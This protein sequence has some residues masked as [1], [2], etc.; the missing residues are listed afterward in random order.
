MTIKT[1]GS[2]T[3]VNPMYVYG[4]CGN[5]SDPSSI[6]R[7]VPDGLYEHISYENP[8][9]KRSGNCRH[10]KITGKLNKSS[11]NYDMRD[12]AC[13]QGSVGPNSYVSDVSR[14]IRGE[15]YIKTELFELPDLGQLNAEAYETMKPSLVAGF[16]LTNFVLELRDVR[17]MFDIWKRADSYVKNIGAGYL[18]YQFGWKLF[19]HDVNDIWKKLSTWEKSLEDYKSKQGKPC[20]RHFRKVLEPQVGYFTYPLSSG[21]ESYNWYTKQTRKSVFHATMLYTYTVPQIDSEFAKLR[22]IG[23]IFGIRFNSSV[24][25]EALP[26]SFVVD[27]FVGVGSYLKAKEKDYLESKVHVIDYCYSIKHEDVLTYNK[28]FSNSDPA[29]LCGTIDRTFYERR[30]CL[31][32]AND[33]GLVASHKYG[34]KQ[35]LLSAALLV[36]R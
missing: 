33:F 8:Q 16:S 32:E 35:M 14:Q 5:M 2:M 15:P 34:S 21:G 11:L 27:W 6:E 9:L 10:T 12:D 7:V 22:A 30:R 31:P 1:R 17:R 26:Y 18:N 19:L 25:W 3:S 29:V 24:I 20:R 13:Y 4:A 23:D 28:D 36:S